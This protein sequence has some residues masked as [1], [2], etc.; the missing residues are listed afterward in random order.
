MSTFVVGISSNHIPA[1]I[2]AL[3]C[4]NLKLFS[5]SAVYLCW[6]CSARIKVFGSCW[7]NMPKRHGKKNYFTETWQ[8]CCTPV[9]TVPAAT[10]LPANERLDSDRKVWEELAY[11]Y[12]DHLYAV[13]RSGFKYGYPWAFLLGCISD[14]GQLLCGM[15]LHACKSDMASF[16]N[17]RLSWLLS[18]FSIKPSLWT[19]H[20]GSK[21]AILMRAE[22]PVC[23][24]GCCVPPWLLQLSASK[25]V[26]VCKKWFH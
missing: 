15:E 25:H 26:A 2:K 19:M 5:P 21:T 1:G 13:I 10:E 4:F 12:S 20:A 22:Q 23:G 6:I 7:R 14:V 16:N 11:S 9:R 8:L 3:F 18:I 24:A 17:A